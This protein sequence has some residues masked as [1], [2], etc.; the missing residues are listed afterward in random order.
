MVNT[1]HT[2]STVSRT[3][4][5]QGSK[6]STASAD[7]T[8][9]WGLGI[10]KIASSALE[11]I[12]GAWE[13]IWTPQEE[14]K[15]LQSKRFLQ[16][17]ASF[18]ALFDLTTLDGE[19]GFQLNANGANLGLSISTKGDING[20][21][22]KDL[23]IG[24]PDIQGTGTGNSYIVFGQ[25]NG[26][27]AQLN[28]AALDGTNGFA[29]NGLGK[30][31]NFGIAVS[32]G[33]LNHDG[34]DDLVLGAYLASPGG[35]TNAGSAFVIFGKRSGWTSTFNLSS[36]NGANGFAI[37][38]RSMGVSLGFPALIEGDING[39]N[40]TDL[41]LGGFG[42]DVG[43]VDTG[44]LYILFGKTSGWT[45]PF[46]LASL[47]GINGFSIS[48]TGASTTLGYACSYA[49]DL[50]GDG[51]DDLAI[52][53]P[54][55][56]VAAGAGA[57]YV[58]YGKTSDWQATFS[59]AAI[60]GTN[61]FR[62]GGLGSSDHLGW[63]ISTAGDLNGD[64]KND[65][66]IGAFQ[67]SPG[68]L[69]GAGSAYILF[70]PS[71]WPAV[72]NLANLNGTNGL[73]VDGLKAN[74]GLGIA[75]NTAGDLNGDG[76]SDLTIGAWKESTGA[77]T[78]AGST[79][80][81]FQTDVWPAK[82]NL[83]SLNGANGF[84]IKGLA[85]DSYLGRGIDTAG[86]LNGDGMADLAIGAS[87]FSLTAA[88]TGFVIFG[89]NTFPSSP[90]IPTPSILPPSTST[91]L[92]TPSILIPASKVMSPSVTMPP[93]EVSSE[94]TPE[95]AF[96]ILTPPPVNEPNSPPTI[97]IAA[98]VASVIVVGGLIGTIVVLR[99]KKKAC[100]AEKNSSNYTSPST[101]MQPNNNTDQV[102]VYQTE[103]P[104]LESVAKPEYNTSTVNDQTAYV[105]NDQTLYGA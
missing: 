95:P 75:I 38:G 62:I 9:N 55:V 13:K 5:Y 70:Q 43:A 69:T 64:G 63:S 18:P 26:W 50:N 104:E 61:G 21:G 92:P 7:Q 88:G 71:V 56:Y 15:P 37:H 39:D 49:R 2:N 87:S 24:A 76:K 42:A 35:L 3:T 25:P 1:A 103:L 59:V 98:G 79:Y 44:I 86:D 22:V 100:F 36:L 78:N 72:F 8:S 93:I 11:K 105:G 20:D 29:V 65:L 94:M 83:S 17:S 66:A 68:G 74:S 14:P 77:L 82:F 102:I 80:I 48:G 10:G 4:D 32:G 84:A 57:V 6:S 41:V 51:I 40:M 67:A 99:V 12:S 54:S 73:I 19:N 97:P 45:S 91:P 52:G 90:A 53:A 89:K 58:V 27:P 34:I 81:L 60:N 46:D 30:G 85:I 28:L 16:Q 47:N 96:M 23:I 31:S 101:Q 33:D